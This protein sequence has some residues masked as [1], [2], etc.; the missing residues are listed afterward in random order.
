MTRR[1][2]EKNRGIARA[3][4]TLAKGA[5][6]FTVAVSAGLAAAAIGDA[7]AAQHILTQFSAILDKILKIFI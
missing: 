3:L 7:T 2:I 4:V 6:G 5:A 1:R